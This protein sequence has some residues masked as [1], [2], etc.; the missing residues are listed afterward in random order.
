M[1]TEN[2]RLTRKKGIG[3]SDVAAILGFSDYKTAADIYLEKTDQVA[4]GPSEHKQAAW[5]QAVEPI[6]RDLFSNDY[7]KSV[8]VP[9]ETLTHDRYPWM[10]ANIDGWLPEEKAVLEIKTAACNYDDWGEPGS[11]H[12]PA[13]YLLQCAHYAVVTDASCVYIYAAINGL[14]PRLFTYSRNHLLE[15]RIISIEKEFWHKHVLKQIPPQELTFRDVSK[16]YQKSRGTRIIADDK[17]RDLAIRIKELS[18]KIKVLTDEQDALKA[19]LCSFIKDND[20][21]VDDD[22]NV[23]AT[24]KTHTAN[25]LD[26]GTLKS[27]R[28]D[29]YS[30]FIQKS[31]ARRLL[32]K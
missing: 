9:T 8:E 4:S 19:N 6:I 30:D 16:L 7:G 21:L 18:S 17:T 12:I 25:R 27:E 29:V 32:I 22:D 11:D 5:G 1:L 15:Q 2:Q 20:I 23:L 31:S 28:P 14:Y 26:V 3:G 10:I 13:Q 24:W